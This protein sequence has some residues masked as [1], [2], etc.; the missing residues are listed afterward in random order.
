MTVRLTLIFAATALASSGAV[1]QESA[2]GAKPPETQ[3]ALTPDKQL[4]LEACDAR[5]FETAVEVDVD[6]KR[7]GRKV[8]LCGKVGQTDADWLKTLKDAAKKFETNQT[9]RPAVRDQIV[10]ALSAEIAKV[11]AGMAISLAPA[12][13]SAPPLRDLRSDYAVVPPIPEPLKPAATSSAASPGLNAEP[14]KTAERTMIAASSPVSAAKKPRLTIKCLS[15]GESGG[16]STCAFFERSTLLNIIADED[17]A[18]GLSLR[19]VR[20]GDVRGEI[21]LAAMEQGQAL[22]SKLP[23]QLCAGV[24]TAKAEIEVVARAQGGPGQVVDRL[25]PFG[26]RCRG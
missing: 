3:E 21:A 25:G 20:K 19:F 4:F 16:G 22:R 6:G 9:M 5:K 26:L 11:E 8:T 7:R 14:M 12:D 23:S 15:P 2:E 24:L 1:A 13:A 17:L 18:A 10:A